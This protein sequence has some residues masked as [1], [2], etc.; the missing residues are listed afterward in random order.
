[1]NG[2]MMD[3]PLTLRHILQRSAKIYPAKEIASK[4]PDGSMRRYRTETSMRV[5]TSWRTL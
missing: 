2:L 1:M 3:Y 4:M 5:Y